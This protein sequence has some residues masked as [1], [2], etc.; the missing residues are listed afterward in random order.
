[1]KNNNDMK[2]QD[3]EIIL[4]VSRQLI[5][6]WKLN[7]VEEDKNLPVFKI[8]KHRQRAKANTEVHARCIKWL[9]STT[10][11]GISVITQ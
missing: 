2:M 11:P 9:C 6:Y 4:I 10:L 8:Q 5:Y 1:M 7:S 3:T